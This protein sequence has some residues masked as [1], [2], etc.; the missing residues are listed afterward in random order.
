MQND[1]VSQYMTK[2]KRSF[3]QPYTVITP[4]TPLADLE[5]FLVDKLF[6]LGMSLRHSSRSLSVTPE[7]LIALRMQSRTPGGSSFS[8]S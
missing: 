2:F 6:A 7:T 1:K 5:L 4:S 3:S 8:P